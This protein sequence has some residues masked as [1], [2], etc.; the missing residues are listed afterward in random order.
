MAEARC[1]GDSIHFNYYKLSCR[2]QQS[3]FVAAARHYELGVD[4]ASS[5]FL[6]SRHSL[7]RLLAGD[8]NVVERMG[9]DCDSESSTEEQN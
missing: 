8:K 1:Q 3:H 7:G 9:A 6:A 4:K 5:A 2:R